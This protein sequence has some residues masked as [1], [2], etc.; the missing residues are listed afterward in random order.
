M[1]SN[2]PEPQKLRAF[3]F[4]QLTEE[5]L[6][7]VSSHVQQCPACEKTVA[8]LRETTDT[9]A[10]KAPDALPRDEVAERPSDKSSP[11]E[12]KPA[13]EA[14]GATASFQNPLSTA[15]ADAREFDE[16][17]LMGK[18]GEGGM[19][20]VYKAQHRRMHRLVAIK[21]LPPTTMK[22]PEAI[23][24][25][26]REVEAAA[27]LMH[28]NIVTAF[29]AGECQGTHY[30]VMEYVE[31]QDLA[32]IVKQHGPLPVQKA[33]DYVLQTARGLQYAHGKGVVH[34]DIKPGNLLLDKKG[35]VKILDMGLARL[36]ATAARDDSGGERLTQSGQMMGTCEYMAPEQAL[37]THTADARSDIYSLGC[38][39]YRLLIGQPPYHGDTLMKVLLA[40]RELPIPSLRQLRQDVPEQ[41]DA[42]F[43]KMMAKE[44]EDRYQSM[45]EVIVELES[46]KGA[47]S[48]RSPAE[49]KALPKASKARG[50]PLVVLGLIGGLILL[51]AA[52]LTFTF[53]NGTLV[54]EIDEKLGKDVQVTVS[55]GGQEVKV[56]DEKSGWTLSLSPGKYGLAVQGGE[57]KFQLDSQ[58][59]TVTRGGQ[60][61]VRVMLKA[62]AA[63][64]PRPLAGEGGH[65]VR[66]VGVRA[67]DPPPRLAI[68]PFDDKEAKEHQEAWAKHLGVPVEMTNEIGM[69]LVLIPP[70]EVTMG[71]GDDVH[72]VT[73]TKPF[74]L[75]KYEVMQEE[76]GRVMSNNPSEFKGLENPVE[77]VSW[78]DCQDFLKKLSEKCRMA[79]GSY[80]LPTAAQSEYACRAGSMG[81]WCFGDSE[82]GLDDYG[83]F[84]SNSE[85]KTH[86]VG[87]KKPNVWGLYDVHGNVSEWCAD[88]F[89][90]D[91][92]EASPISDPMGPSSGSSRVNRGGCWTDGADRCRS[93]Y[94]H[95]S[96]PSDRLRFVG[97]RVLQ[98]LADKPEGIS[99]EA[100][101]PSTPYSVPNTTSIAPAPAIA[102]PGAQSPARLP[103]VGSLIGPDGKWKL[104]PGAPSP[105][106]APFDATKAKEHQAAWAKHLGV[107][108]EITNSIGM[109]LV[110]IP[111][112]EF[113]MGSP[114]EL[115]EEELKT[116]PKDDK[117]YLVEHLPGEGPRHHVRITRPFYLGMYPVTQEEYQRV[118][119]ASPSEFS[120]TGK[121]KDK[122]AGQ[123]TKRFPVETVSWSDSDEFCSRLSEMA[124]EKSAGRRYR[125]P[126]EAQWEYAC[127][128]GSTGRWFS[129]LHRMKRRPKR[130]CCPS[131]PGSATTRADDRTRWE[132][133]EPA[134][135]DCMIC[136]VTSGSGARI[137]A[138]TTTTRNRLRMPLL[139][140][141]EART[142]C[143][144]AV[145]GSARRG[146]AGRRAAT[147]TSPGAA[148]TT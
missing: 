96:G 81:G 148:A 115:I 55:Q 103:A 122:V 76:W 52:V 73:I 93:A 67:V 127:R 104:P 17:L 49:S 32:K 27:K 75:G 146:S 124:E 84:K 7:S 87:G 64:S 46:V 48:S 30:L 97:L 99:A 82:P 44:P 6:E 14:L 5:S 3:V 118:M 135:G 11:A 139:G 144:A 88:W 34:R 131:T 117:S 50:K 72:K 145:A 69:K 58:N 33:V 54:V 78:D 9:D 101:V 134:R 130:T 141:R 63:G 60:A 123:D 15:G 62:E 13:T 85:G 68:A 40:H 57:D 20:V 21:M 83:W 12:Q 2:C 65:H 42:V 137:G 77:R 22:S 129:A 74:Y 111:P 24:R 147:T 37:D 133:G 45:A 142:A 70:G 112:G 106:I 116:A 79:A 53:R 119:G 105:A 102:S 1:N 41:L 31:G 86:S 100:K 128:A 114:P 47:L 25:F 26:Y 110:L 125:L 138:P 16:Y 71:E 140:L 132:E 108:V 10:G 43:Q 126:S 109:K 94:R 91:N 38:T 136:M 39:L 29:D 35:T 92:Y 90:Q 4:G 95:G 80:R 120:T 28:P 89:A 23:Q 107:P 19:G 121:S 8:A 66:M 113:E 18:L 98:V 36:E 56:A 143:S 51:L 59:V 61:K